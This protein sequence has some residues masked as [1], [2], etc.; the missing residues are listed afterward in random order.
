METRIN[1]E[2]HCSADFREVKRVMKWW[3]LFVFCFCFL[4]VLTYGDDLDIC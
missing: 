1:S 3:L 2:H 4:L